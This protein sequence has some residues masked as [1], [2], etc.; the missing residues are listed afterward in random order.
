MKIW[1]DEDGEKFQN[2]EVCFGREYKPDGSN[3]DVAKISIRGEFP[4]NGGWGWLEDTHEMAV[5]TKGEGYI[6]TKDGGK[7]TI[8]TGD[9]IYV[10]PRKWFRWGG[11]FDMITPCSPAFDPSKHHLE[12][13]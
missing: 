8:V 5:I 12:E 3:I 1:H 11:N 13:A 9:V 6:E 7:V 4:E 2:S 10:E